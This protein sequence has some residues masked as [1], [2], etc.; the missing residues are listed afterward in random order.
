[1][2]IK[3]LALDVSSEQ[4]AAWLRLIYAYNARKS[5]DFKLSVIVAG[6]VSEQP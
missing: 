6:E 5:L 2:P 3:S 4:Q 1:M